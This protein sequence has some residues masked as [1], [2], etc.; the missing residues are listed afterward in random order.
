MS[1][2][3]HKDNTL[4]LKPQEE[5]RFESATGEYGG[6]QTGNITIIT[7]SSK[8][9]KKG[10]KGESVEDIVRHKEPMESKCLCQATAHKLWTNCTSCGYIMC[11]LDSRNS[12]CTFCKNKLDECLLPR[13]SDSSREKEEKVVLPVDRQLQA[14]IERKDRLINFDRNKVCI[15]SL[16][17]DFV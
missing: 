5:K 12:F 11:E 6:R 13:V 4:Y 15:T 10:K 14:A 8:H 17:C 16:I 2:Y 3:S 9:G 7:K 1:A